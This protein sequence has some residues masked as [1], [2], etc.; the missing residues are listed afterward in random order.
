MKFRSTY[1]RARDVKE[2]LRAHYRPGIQAHN[3][4]AVYKNYIYRQTGIS[5]ATMNRYLAA[6]T[7]TL[8]AQE[9]ARQLKI[10]FNG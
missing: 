10:P 9:D 8:P 5:R 4:T 7:D 2:I 1:L 6:D 3:I